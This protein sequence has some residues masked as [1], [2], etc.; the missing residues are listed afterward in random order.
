MKATLFKNGKT[1][2]RVDYWDMWELD[3]TLAKIIYPCLVKFKENL[4]GHPGDLTF[5][6][7]EEVLDKIAWSMNEIIKDDYLIQYCIQEGEYEWDK[8]DEHENK[9]QEGCELLGRYFRNLWE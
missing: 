3:I 1:N 5:E 4:D 8:I 7:W 2:V 9:M 6:Q